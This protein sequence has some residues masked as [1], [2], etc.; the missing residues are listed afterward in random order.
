MSKLNKIILW[1]VAIIII[2]G[3]IW[4]GYSEREVV[5][6]GE[7]IK[8][9]YIGAITGSTAKFG[10]YEAVQLAVEDINNKGGINGKKIKLI[11]EDGKCDPKSA[12]DSVNKLINFDNV[13]FI[14]GGHCSPESVSIAPIVEKNKVIMLASITT[15][16]LLTDMGDYV[17]RTSPSSA[18]IEA[19][20]IADLAIKEGLSNMA[21]I[22]AQ[23]DHAQPIAEKLRDE[24]TQKRGIVSLFE[25][26]LQN[27]TDFRTPI[28][29]AKS[30]NVD[31][32]FLSSQAPDESYN[33]MKQLRELGIESRVFGNTASAVQSIIDK[34][35]EIFEGLIVSQPSFDVDNEKTK[36][37][38]DKYK[39]KYNVGNIPFGIWTAE[40]YDAVFILAD[41]IKENGEDVEKVKEYLYQ[42]KDFEGASGKISI[43][44]NGDGVREYHPIIIKQGKFI[45]YEIQ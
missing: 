8:I 40:S 15:N 14:L 31:S 43:D 45:P 33:F 26:Y 25:S 22:Y 36:E 20:L 1:L 39:E 12:V 6:E 44:E 38:V 17:F 42:V 28:L 11:A 9:G 32:I 13:K 30:E 27:N 37:F 35:P 2:V 19:E 7:V 4:L 3:L 16:P 34:N 24:F 41:A 29:K 18:S 5:E 21:I 23:T 10:S